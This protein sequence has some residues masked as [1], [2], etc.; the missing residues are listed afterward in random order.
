[1]KT[2]TVHCDFPAIYRAFVT[3]EAED[4]VHACRAAIDAA[5]D[6]DAWKAL[7]GPAMT[8]VAAI[9]EGA[10]VDP[11]RLASD[12]TDT[13]VLPVPRPFTDVAMIAGYAAT[14][15]VDLID[16]LQI[17]IDAI[18]ADGRLRITPDA[19]VRLRAK[20]K[21]ILDDLA[22]FGLGSTPSAAASVVADRPVLT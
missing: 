1:M 21:A 18:S 12:E 3:V 15:T 13:S 22:C 10:D 2:F 19:M 6:T 17:M 4:V 5:N 9:A 7:D 20:G 8:C 16:Q 11:W 14:R